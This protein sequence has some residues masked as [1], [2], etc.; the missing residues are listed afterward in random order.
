MNANIAGE[1]LFAV[2]VLVCQILRIFKGCY[3]KFHK[4]KLEEDTGSP[5]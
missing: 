3:T 4:A 1:M 2:H 5:C